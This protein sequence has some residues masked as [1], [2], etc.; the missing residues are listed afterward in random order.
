MLV[1]DKWKVFVL[2]RRTEL[3]Y[4]VMLVIYLYKWERRKKK[5]IYI[6]RENPREPKER[7]KQKKRRKG[8]RKEK[9]WKR[10]IKRG[11]AS[12]FPF[13]LSS[14]LVITAWPSRNFLLDMTSSEEC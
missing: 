13:N 2:L 6:E 12:F 1:H 4:S 7:E 10:K 14:S 8:R 9:K 11:S 3:Y 5:Y